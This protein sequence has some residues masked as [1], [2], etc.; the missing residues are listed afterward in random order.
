MASLVT[1]VLH[2]ETEVQYI[3][4]DDT[5]H[6]ASTAPLQPSDAIK[7]TARCGVHRTTASNV[8][9]MIFRFHNERMVE[10]NPFGEWLARGCFPVDPVTESMERRYN[11]HKLKVQATHLPCTPAY[12]ITCHKLQGCTLRAL[13]IA[14]WSTKELAALYVLLSRVGRLD[15]IYLYDRVPQSPDAYTPRVDV[16]AEYR[17]LQKHFCDPTET[18]IKRFVARAG[19]LVRQ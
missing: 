18:A 6:S 4:F 11:G 7:A 12:A 15:D 3:P 19:A 17:R 9:A 16:I 2:N 13:A 14:S 5:K 10:A 1:I 8:K